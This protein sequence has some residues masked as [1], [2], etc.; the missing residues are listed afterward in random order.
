[1]TYRKE[2]KIPLH[3]LSLKNDEHRGRKNKRGVKLVEV[4]I[5]F[6]FLVCI[7]LREFLHTT[8]V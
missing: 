2:S 1:M 4:E 7:H 5:F 6:F 8:K 3:E